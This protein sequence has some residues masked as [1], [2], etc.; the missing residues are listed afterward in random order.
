ME[1]RSTKV[2]KGLKKIEQPKDGIIVKHS[3]T[4]YRLSQ[5]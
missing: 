1:Q 2:K 5:L 4:M 3:L